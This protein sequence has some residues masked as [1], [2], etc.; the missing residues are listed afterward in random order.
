MVLPPGV[1]ELHKNWPRGLTELFRPNDPLKDPW[2][3]YNTI[4]PVNWHH[5]NDDDEE[6]L[7]GEEVEG[8]DREVIDLTGPD[9]TAK[10]VYSTYSREDDMVQTSGRAPLL[11][12]RVSRPQ[13][14]NAEFTRDKEFGY[15]S[16][17]MTAGSAESLPGFMQVKTGD[18]VGWVGCGDGRELI[19]M[20]LLHPHSSFKGYDVNKAAVL[21]AQRKA[22]QLGCTN[23]TFEHRDAL[24]VHEKFHIVFSTAIAGAALYIHLDTMVDTSR[25]GSV[26][27]VLD[28]MS[29][30]TI[31]QHNSLAVKLAGSGGQKMLV[32]TAI[33]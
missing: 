22:A 13:V 30:T 19:F 7:E 16:L 33:T 28:E 29:N 21:M 14:R 11:G 3:V 15:F 23:A 6:I 18:T 17:N 5:D 9:I 2:K 12:K 8:E 26:L 10:K 4:K 20:A 24:T 1:T 27:I 25:R 32:K 31:T